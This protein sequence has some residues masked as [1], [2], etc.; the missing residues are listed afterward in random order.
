M[1]FYFPYK[2]T[3]LEFSII[4]SSLNNLF[5]LIYKSLA[6]IDWLIRIGNFENH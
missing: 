2:F 3:V 1:I 5:I 6:E 4:N